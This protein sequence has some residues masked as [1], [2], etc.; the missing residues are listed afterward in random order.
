MNPS[1]VYEPISFT[2]N[3]TAVIAASAPC[4]DSHAVNMTGIDGRK[5]NV[6]GS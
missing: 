4:G 3:E 5:T 6:P 1:Q 2:I